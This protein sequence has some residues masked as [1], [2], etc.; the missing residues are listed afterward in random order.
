MGQYFY[1]GQP[2]KLRRCHCSG[3]TIHL[4]LFDF[5][6][7][8]SGNPNS[9]TTRFRCFGYQEY[10]RRDR[11]QESARH[12]LRLFGWAQ[13]SLKERRRGYRRG[14]GVPVLRARN[15]HNRLYHRR[16][17]PN[18]RVC[19]NDPYQRPLRC[20]YSLC[21]LYRRRFSIF[22]LWAEKVRHWLIL[23]SRNRQDFFDRN[24]A[25]PKEPGAPRARGQPLWLR[26]VWDL[27]RAVSSAGPQQTNRRWR[28]I[29]GAVVSWRCL[30][31]GSNDLQG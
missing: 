26:G 13:P 20:F 11:S 4:C 2:P 10:N 15:P 9:P 17:N 22:R 6:A 23:V 21:Y 27:L 30:R 8:R 16:D 3:A 19:S 5:V 18:S 24:P 29:S 31:T 1:L 25:S 14:G 12:D 7:E 28:T